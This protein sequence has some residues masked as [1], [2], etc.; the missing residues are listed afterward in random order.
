M[1]QKQKVHPIRGLV[2][3]IGGIT[4]LD[5][6]SAKERSEADRRYRVSGFDVY[7]LHSI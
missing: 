3:L 2:I 7:L 1:M 4:T 5:G 6:A